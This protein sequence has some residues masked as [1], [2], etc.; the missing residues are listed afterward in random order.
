M[1]LLR[2]IVAELIGMFLGDARL[3]T[4]ILALVAVVAGLVLWLDAKDA[5][6]VVLAAG[7]LF[8]LVEAAVRESRK[9]GRP[10]L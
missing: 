7:C 6:A 1:T 4:A 2:D 5:A 9:R 3:T 10:K 8:V